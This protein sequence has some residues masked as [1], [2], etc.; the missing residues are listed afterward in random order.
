MDN[1]N[2]TSTLLTLYYLTTVYRL[3]FVMYS[4]TRESNM[5]VH[6]FTSDQDVQI[7]A[8][9]AAGANSTAL[10]AKYGTSE[11]VIMHAVRRAGGSVRPSIAK[12][13]VDAARC[14]GCKSMK[15]ASSFSRDPKHRNGLTSVC[16]LCRAARRA[17]ERTK[18]PVLSLS[19]EQLCYLA[20]LTDGEG[21]IGAVRHHKRKIGGG[22]LSPRFQIAMTTPMLY[23]L[24]CEFGVGTV[25]RPTM[26]RP[27]DDRR[28]EIY[29]WGLGSWGC[30]ALLPLLVPYLRLKK[31]QAILVIQLCELLSHKKITSRSSPESV[32][33]YRHELESIHS[34]LQSLN[35]KGR[36]VEVDQG[37]VLSNK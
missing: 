20:G 12:V 14:S 5:A 2:H 37:S 9:Y 4:L 3:T 23:D 30:R 35:Q 10:A 11:T 25:C 7:A 21:Y 1:S 6:F 31:P 27:R 33:E 15:P 28:R 22:G 13:T 34:K 24:C 18:P 26:N 16:H 8:E 29:S 17:H 36:R 32:Q 19:P